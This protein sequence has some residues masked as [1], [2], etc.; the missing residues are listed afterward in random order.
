MLTAFFVFVLGACTGSFCS[1]LLYRTRY[2]GSIVS[3]RSQCIACKQQLGPSDLV[4]IVSWL[5]R[6]GHCRYCGVGFS[7]QYLALE[8]GA[9]ALFLGAYYRFCGFVDLCSPDSLFL[10]ARLAVFGVFLLLIFVYDARHGEIPDSFTVTGAIVA[11]L[12]NIFM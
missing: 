10:A 12:F 1:A 2:G 5:I 4:P 6:R 11:L 7:W 9:G 8:A 3:G